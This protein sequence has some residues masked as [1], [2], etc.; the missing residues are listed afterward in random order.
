MKGKPSPILLLVLRASYKCTFTEKADPTAILLS[1]TMSLTGASTCPTV[2]SLDSAF[3]LWLGEQGDDAYACYTAGTCSLGSG[4]S[5]NGA[6]D[7][8]IN[9]AFKINQTQATSTDRTYWKTAVL[10][11]FLC[12]IFPFLIEVRDNTQWDI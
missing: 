6:T 5:C 2:A 4:S 8:K 3:K 9:Y 1:S 12:Y 11:N 7:S 10:T